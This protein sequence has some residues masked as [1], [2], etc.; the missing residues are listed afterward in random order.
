[1]YSQDEISV[2]LHS[3]QDGFEYESIRLQER[4]PVEFAMTNLR[5]IYADYRFSN[6]TQCG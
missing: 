2:A 6:F 1:M 5:S 3:T 4:S